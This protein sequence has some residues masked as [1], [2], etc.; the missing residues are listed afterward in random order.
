[1]LALARILLAAAC[2][3]PTIPALIEIDA[4]Q[5]TG[6]FDEMLICSG[7]EIVQNMT[8]QGFD[9]LLA[10]MDVPLLR[11]GGIAAEYY[12]WEG[13]DY[14]GLYYID[15]NGFI[16]EDTLPNS[17]DDLLQLCEQVDVEPILT[18]NHHINDPGKARR[19]VEYCNGDISTP[20]G[21]VRASRGHPAPYDVSLWCIGNEPDIAGN[22]WPVPPWGDWTFYRHFG[23]PF[24][25]WA[26]DDSV[27]CTAEDFADLVAVY[28]D[29]MR[30]ASP[31][32]I[33]I[34]GLSLAEDLS[35]IEP[36][37]GGNSDAID[38]MDIHY[39]PV[40]SW[41]ADSAQYRD[42]L[43]APT[44]GTVLKPPLEE[45]YPVVVDTVE[46]HSGT[47]E[48]PVYVLEYNVIVIADS[49]VW[50][51]YLDGLFV[52]DCIG[53]FS[54]VSAPMIAQYSIVEGEPGAGE[55]PLFGALRGD[56]LSMRASAWALRLYAE[57]FGG[58]LVQT[59]C[60][61]VSGGYGLEAYASRFDDWTLSLMVINKNL[62]D[63]YTAT[64]TLENYLSDGT[65]E[66]WSITNDAPM[67]APW[68]GTTGI[69]W[70]GE[71]TGS[72]STFNYEFPKASITCIWIHPD[73]EGVPGDPTPAICGRL[74]VQPSPF[75]ESTCIEFELDTPAVVD[76]SVFD[77]AGRRIRSLLKADACFGVSRVV[78]NGMDDRGNALPP[79]VYLI[80]MS[81]DGI[82][83][84]RPVLRL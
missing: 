15:I 27:F 17:L 51:N 22:V 4:L 38:W 47:S 18:V 40:I 46:A 72:A 70:E 29:S 39:Y 37:I 64:I 50:W 77:L 41:S 44:S 58:I 81:C 78:W 2:S 66:A 31:I 76:L 43:A 75:T 84:S 16:I 63:S 45:W 33:E 25:D 30:S 9:S 11:M 49:P 13:N 36:V 19:M 59:V 67:Q 82:V 74:E 68:N 53:H 62:D 32:P 79:G 34:G 26:V 3:L 20:M 10:V 73:P 23:I 69:S 54:R 5:E 57:R 60:D 21:A 12:D 55:F 56:T 61:Q 7:D 8:M 6:S 1:M 24:A 48:I 52:A 14:N 42:W 35:W 28:V 83:I 71:F 80:R 65:A